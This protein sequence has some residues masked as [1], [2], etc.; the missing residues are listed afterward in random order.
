MVAASAYM[1]VS[2]SQ[3]EPCPGGYDEQQDSPLIG[4]QKSAAH[5]QCCRPQVLMAVSIALF[6]G[7]CLLFAGSLTILAPSD[8]K[9]A[10]QLPSYCGFQVSRLRYSDV[11]EIFANRNFLAPLLVAVEYYE[12]DWANNFHQESIYRGLPTPELELAWCDEQEG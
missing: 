5:R 3:E 10:M 4:V 7:A 1:R 12:V 11:H 8:R 9:C 2:Q 6:G